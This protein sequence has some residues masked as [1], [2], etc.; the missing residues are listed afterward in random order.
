MKTF[1]KNQLEIDENQ[2]NFKNQLEIDENEKFSK[3]FACK[4]WF[5]GAL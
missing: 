3:N 5:W 4:P 1:S 2:K